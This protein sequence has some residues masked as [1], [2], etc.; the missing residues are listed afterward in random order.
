MT[1]GL[2]AAGLG[3]TLYAS[4]CADDSPLFV[5]VWYSLATAFVAAVGAFVGRRVLRY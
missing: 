5:M 1:A 3:A 4:H 2:L